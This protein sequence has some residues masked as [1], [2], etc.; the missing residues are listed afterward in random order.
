MPSRFVVWP[1]FGSTRG[2]VT[3]NVEFAGAD[4]AEAVGVL[5]RVEARR[6]NPAES[7]GMLDVQ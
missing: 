6:E 7:G 2:T 5:E 3:S 4:L 1:S